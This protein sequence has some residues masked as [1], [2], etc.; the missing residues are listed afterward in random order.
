MSGLLEIMTLL[1]VL[2]MNIL[3]LRGLLNIMGEIGEVET[4][5]FLK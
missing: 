4:G 3:L 1:G 2:M 5:I